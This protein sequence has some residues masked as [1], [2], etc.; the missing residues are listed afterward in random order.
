MAPPL[1]PATLRS[2]FSSLDPRRSLGA[3]A[4]WLIIALAVT[5]S[6]TA[7]MWVGSI[8]RK[9]VLEQHVRRLSLETDQ[10]STDLGQAIAARLD[11]VRS[12]VAMSSSAGRDSNDVAALFNELAGNYPRLDWLA[13][14]DEQGRIVAITGGQSSS[15]AISA[16]P[17]VSHGLRGP[18]FGPI[19]GGTKPSTSTDYTDLGDMAIPIRGKSDRNVGVIAAH[20]RWRRAAHHS[21]RL[22]DEVDPRTT[23]EVYVLDKAGVVMLGPATLIG[24]R[25]PGVVVHK[26][27]AA[28]LTNVMQGSDAPQ[29]EQLPEGRVALISQSCLSATEEIAALGWR[30]VLSEPYQRVF[31]RADALTVRILWV[32][33]CLGVITATLGILG[34]RHLTRRLERLAYSVGHVGQGTALLEVPHGADEVAR[35]GQAFAKLL[36]ELAS[37]RSELERRV[38]MRTREVERLADESRYAAIGRERLRIARELHDTL[39]HSMMAILIEIRFLRRL[40]ARDPKA[41]GNELVRAEAIAHEGLQEARRAITQMRVTKVQESGLGPALAETFKRFINLTGIA[42]D[43]IVDDAAARFGDDRAELIVRIA[44]EALRN[45]ERH[46]KATNVTVTLRSVTDE[47]LM[48]Q[49]EDNGIGFDA[50]QIP[51]GHYGIIGLREQAELIGAELNIQ[52]TCGEGT[53]LR[54]VLCL[55]PVRF[56]SMSIPLRPGGPQ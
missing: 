39:A 13:A 5:F 4:M 41:L 38:L 18:W 1:L 42:G 49:I 2:V 53:V 25:W 19:D 9:N 16:L 28:S 32:S 44:Q 3:A 11:A 36:A 55:P 48:L 51:A 45:I 7:A 37:E 22:T 31:Q 14:A 6:I 20:M 26:G 46:A 17:W 52:S 24:K 21:E 12:A 34:A 10:L 23:T 33:L 47:A 40:H 29:F 27:A 54:L 30:I 15:K 8:A 43:F 35:L 50:R 56:E